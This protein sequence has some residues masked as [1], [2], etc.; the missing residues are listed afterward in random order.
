MCLKPSLIQNTDLM[1]AT[2]QQNLNLLPTITGSIYT[3]HHPTTKNARIAIRL[4]RVVTV[5]A[6]LRVR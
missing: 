2:I 6:A 3:N 4:Y 5:E 1:S